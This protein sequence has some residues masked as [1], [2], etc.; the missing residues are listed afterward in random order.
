MPVA[1]AA[2]NDFSTVKQAVRWDSR[3]LNI[4][5]DQNEAFYNSGELY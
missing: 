5:A 2:K 1:I 3:P 4:K